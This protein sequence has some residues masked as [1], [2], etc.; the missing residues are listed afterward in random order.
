M[1]RFFVVLAAAGL[2]AFAAAA[3]SAQTEPLPG[4]PVAHVTVRQGEGLWQVAERLC[5]EGLFGQYQ[6]LWRANPWT[7]TVTLQPGAV[8]HVPEGTCT[9]TTTT[10]TAPTTTVT[11]APPS[12]DT[13]ATSTAVATTD[14]PTPSTEPAPTPPE[15]TPVT[16]PE[17]PT[18]P[19][20]SS[21][22]TTTTTSPPD[23]PVDLAGY[24]SPATTGARV[25]P[26]QVVNGNLT[27]TAAGQVIEDVIVNGRIIVRH[28]NV[29]IRDVVVRAAGNYGIDIGGTPCATGTTIEYVTIDMAAARADQS[30]PL[31]QRCPG[32]LTIDHLE[33][34]NTGRDVRIAGGGVTVTDSFMF[35][36]A[37]WP[38][39]HR[40]AM[41]T[42]GGSGFVVR[43][44]TFVCVET[45]CSSSLN[46]Y[47]DYAP[48]TDYLLEDNLFAGG[49]ICVRGGNSHQYAAETRDIRIL[50]NRFSQVFSPQCG[51]FQAIGAFDASAPGNVAAGNVWHETG[52]PVPGR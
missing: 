36:N 32:V 5:P 40:T 43:H 10:T 49:S 1:R 3:V 47:S 26:S 29:T 34:A 50:N 39:A 52:L 24:P 16:E 42:H 20:T 31:Y 7:S 44:N 2:A 8:L 15:T 27:T 4:P 48:V 51:T 21:A 30:M 35:S 38:G 19:P 25:E 22:A 6:A 41:S 11:V 23:F 14:A 28:D 18:S 9:P 33:L 17:P 13:T 12:T 46:M 45:G 37:T